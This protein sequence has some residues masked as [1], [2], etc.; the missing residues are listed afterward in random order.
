ML[1]FL[2]LAVGGHVSANTRAARFLRD[3]ATALALAQ[4]GVEMA[5]GEIMANPSN[6]DP[7]ALGALPNDEEKFRDNASLAGGLFSVF[8][9]IVDTNV[10]GIVTNFG[11]VRDRG[12]I[13]IDEGLGNNNTERLEQVLG[14]LGA[15]NASALTVE[16]LTNYPSGKDLAPEYANRYGPYEALP[17]LLAVSGVD[18]ALFDGLDPLVTLRE[19]E[20]QYTSAGEAWGRRECYGGVAEG[21][22][23]ATGAAGA[24]AVLATRRITFVFDRVTT[25]LLYWREH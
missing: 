3:D 24:P 11:V 21:R 25:N 13:N 18:G 2:A 23:V 7:V 4:G 9:A 14:W 10:P 12:R 19:F 20:R 22:A 17:E 16:I 6:Y 1:G 8:Y 5:I 15:D